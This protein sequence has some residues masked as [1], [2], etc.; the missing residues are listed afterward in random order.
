VI[1][2]R[3]ALGVRRMVAPERSGRKISRSR[4]FLD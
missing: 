4:L 2:T 1:A 3:M